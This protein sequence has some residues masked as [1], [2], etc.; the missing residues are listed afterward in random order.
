MG[1]VEPNFFDTK[2][3]YLDVRL[4]AIVA[5]NKGTVSTNFSGIKTINTSFYKENIG[6][7]I[8]DIQIDVN[9][10]LQPVIKISF[11]DLYGATVFGGQYNKFG[12][13]YS[14][15]FS[16]PPPKFKFQFKGYLGGYVTWLLNLK[17]YSTAFEPADGS[18][19]ITAEFIPNQFG[20]LAD[21]PYLYLRSVRK[22]RQLLGDELKDGKGNDVPTTFDLIEIGNKV[23]EIA[24][25]VSKNYDDIS[26]K[27]ALLSE[28]PESAVS[29][30][31]I[32]PDEVFRG[33]IQSGA[34]TSSGNQD[35]VDFQSIQIP[36]SYEANGQTIN[37]NSEEVAKLENN[38]QSDVIRRIIECNTLINGS[39]INESLSNKDYNFYIKDDSNTSREDQFKEVRRTFVKTMRTNI[40]LIEELKQAEIYIASEGKIG[41]LTISNVMQTIARDAGYLMGAILDYGLEGEV[42]NPNR[43]TTNKEIIGAN[44]PLFI[45][46]EGAEIP[47]QEFGIKDYEMKLISDFSNSVV[48]S[49]NRE[50]SD[51]LLP[52]FSFDERSKIKN[53]ITNLEI[54]YPNPYKG[55]PFVIARSMILR[56]GVGAFL[57]GSADPNNPDTGDIDDIKKLA[58][59]DFGNVKPFLNDIIAD[60]ENEVNELKVFCDF[61][62][63]IFSDDM[64]EF[65]SSVTGIEDLDFDTQDPDEDKINEYKKAEIILF[66]NDP[67]TLGDILKKYLGEGESLQKRTGVDPTTMRSEY[68]IINGNLYLNPFVAL[69]PN[70]TEPQQGLKYIVFEGNDAT[71]VLSTAKALDYNPDSNFIEG[72]FEIKYETEN[73][74][75]LPDAVTNLEY[76]TG[77]DINRNMGQRLVYSWGKIK[78]FTPDFGDVLDTTSLDNDFLFGYQSNGVGQLPT[79]N[80]FRAAESDAWKSAASG[81]EDD[82]DG[83]SIQNPNS[84]TWVYKD[85]SNPVYAAMPLS[86]PNNFRPGSI[87]RIFD[88]FS[89]SKGSRLQRAYLTEISRLC[90]EELVQVQNEFIRKRSNLVNKFTNAEDDIY[91]QFHSIYQQWSSMAIG[92]NEQQVIGTGANSNLRGEFSTDFGDYHFDYNS[93][94]SELRNTVSSNAKTAFVYQFPLQSIGNNSA[95]DIKIKDAI[96]NIDPLKQAATDA[97]TTVLN[98]IQNLCTKNNFTFIPIP[99]NPGYDSTEDIFS[100]DLDGDPNAQSLFSIFH[101]MFLPT[102]ESRT[103]FSNNTFKVDVVQMRNAVSSEIEGMVVKF[104]SPDNQIVKSVNVDTVDNKVTAESIINLQAL[105]DNNTQTKQVTKDCSV[106]SVM[107][108]R[109]YK[110]KISMLGNAKLFPTQ[111]FFLDRSPLFGGLYQIMSVSHSISPNNM[112]SEIE[113]IRMRFNNDSYGAV[114]PITRASFEEYKTKFGLTG[115]V[116]NKE[117]SQGNTTTTTKEIKGADDN[118]KEADYPE[119]LDIPEVRE[120]VKQVGSL[121]IDYSRQLNSAEYFHDVFDKKFI[122]LHHTA[123]GDKAENSIHWWNI[124]GNKKTG[125]PNRVATSYVIG[126]NDTNK[127]FECFDPK[128]WAYHVGIEGKSN[129]QFQ[130]NSIGIELCSRGKL[131]KEG[132]R[133]LSKDKDGIVLAEI[134]ASEVI[135]LKDEFRRSRY[136]HKYS[137]S[138]LATLEKLLE[139]IIE[140]YD[141]PVQKSFSMNWFEYSRS[142]VENPKDGI[143]SHA[144]VR[145]DK[146]DVYPDTRVLGILKRIGAKYG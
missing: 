14:Q 60:G 11:K 5:G 77:N 104:G 84:N 1:L 130:R 36:S 61:F 32:K 72:A 15:L 102:P 46:K 45:D 21:I 43:R 13:D 116:S 68:L 58:E 69:F 47:A 119:D 38:G 95:S 122:F 27:L 19:K 51:S 57:T 31:L 79:V 110:S 7:G 140:T 89:N 50:G 49:I 113:G 59:K 91:K 128:F 100:P 48:D 96:V 88:L 56:S 37:I 74:N 120:G 86:N 73:S 115:V 144:G 52:N 101:V 133:Y 28:A 94:K 3:L 136:Y 70:S 42:N 71:E 6:F 82:A 76:L 18:Y 132:N 85:S 118:E 78:N 83:D 143:W 44:Y 126:R 105:V 139:Y 108:G 106:L 124:D 24:E 81:S 146:S 67:A 142:Q 4:T 111:F 53:R 17:Q 92:D 137:D 107:A 112:E 141:I 98:V 12:I 129:Y 93:E 64:E 55:D 66:N 97:N 123:G 2:D 29:T 34:Q 75:G 117:Q 80:T 127:A 30:G 25:E 121:T 63:K 125:E 23:T 135:T 87:G 90:F 39:L 22:L 103:N 16:W 99:G 62:R 109:S 33:E 138:Q 10:S 35:I 54:L 26:E 131:V 40:E 65:A 134:P 20:F 145:K 9:T 41:Q 114:L 8:T